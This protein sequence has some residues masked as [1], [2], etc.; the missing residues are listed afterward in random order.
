M[1]AALAVV[2]VPTAAEG[3]TALL[4]GV[5]Y[6]RQV[7]IVGGSG[8]VLHVLRAPKHGGLYGFRPVLSHGTV[9]GRQ[10]IPAMQRG[11][12]R[13]ATAVGVN[14]DFSRWDDGRPSGI[15]LRDGVLANRPYGRRSALGIAFD[16][17]LVVKRFRFVGSWQAAGSVEHPL[18]EFNRPLASPPGM[19]LFTPRWGGLTPRSRR[20]VDVVLRRFP[21][22]LP[23]GYPTGTVV[24]L[25]RGGG[26]AVPRRGAVLH[27]RGFWRDVVRRE[28]QP[29][30]SVTVHIQVPRLPLDVAD[31][32]G[33]GP[34][35]V[36]D[37]EAVVGADEA[38]TFDQISY[39]HPRTA[40]GQLANGRVILVVADGRSS[41]SAGLTIAQLAREMVRLGAVTAMNLDGGGS[42]IL[43]VDGRVLNRPSDGSP[44]P[45]ANGLFVLYYGVYAPPLRRRVI[46]PNGDG[47]I[48]S[49]TLRAKIVRRSG[50]RVRLVRPNG[51]V[52]WRYRD[53]VDP[54][55]ISHRVGPTTRM[56]NG[57]WRWIA[58]AVDLVSG[59]ESRMERAFTVNKTLGF[60]TLSKE[61]M[62]VVAGRGGRLDV[63]VNVTR[64]AR[65]AVVVRN[66][67]G[68]RR[69]TLFSGDVGRGR[70]SWRW[71]GRNDAG[72]VVRSGV[73]TVT[74]RAVNAIG[75]VSLRKA[76]R[77]V[78]VRAS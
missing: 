78:R 21:R 65:L 22:V 27:A 7:R 17:R 30:T 15:F 4:P 68:V 24:E 71:D 34:V 58:D 20:A 57:R 36:R 43:A 16:G 13:R 60:L 51:T 77:V 12:R 70:P 32:V 47:V 54:G 31:A 3:A 45:V 9:L 38:F 11:L 25:R 2:L 67:A 55:W 19:A 42:S 5:T 48:D 74:V 29:G 23:N 59:R 6:E 10:T 64:A 75:A 53:R 18:E 63:S 33:G 56:A 26:T 8:V 41:V 52:A 37:G 76:V 44:R 72:R 69:R 28:A 62:R 49:Q 73:Y 40:V 50:V 35:L 46:S 14:A 1:T 61:R 39:R 66:A